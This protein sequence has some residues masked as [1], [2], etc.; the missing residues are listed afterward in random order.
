MT[1]LRD[2]VTAAFRRANVIEAEDEPDAHEAAEGLEHLNEMFFNME[3]DGFVFTLPPVA[4]ST[5]RGEYTHAAWAIEDTFPFE[6]AYV[7]GLKYMLAVVISEE[8][9]QPA[10][11]HVATG[12]ANGYGRLLNAFYAPATIN[13]ELPLQRVGHSGVGLFSSRFYTG[14]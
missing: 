3:Q 1:T 5:E 11:P 10:P 2:I 7:G 6:E 9:G 13:A 4:P 12:A 8:H 14:G